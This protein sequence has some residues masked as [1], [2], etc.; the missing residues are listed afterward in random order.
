MIFSMF[1]MAIGHHVEYLKVQNF[2]G[3]GVST[4]VAHHAPCQIL[5]KFLHPSQRYC[6]FL[7]F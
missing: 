7:I 6:N 2:I 5:S 3:R 1:H 4:T